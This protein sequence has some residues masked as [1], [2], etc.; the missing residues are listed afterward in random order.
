LGWIDAMGSRYV[1]FYSQIIVWFREEIPHST[2]SLFWSKQ[3]CQYEWQTKE[4]NLLYQQ[5]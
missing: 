5:T 2:A 3:K 1:V 4:Q